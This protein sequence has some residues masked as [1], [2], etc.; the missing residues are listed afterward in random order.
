MLKEIEFILGLKWVLETQILDPV[1]TQMIL[2]IKGGTI[3][4]RQ[5]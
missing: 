4:I 3:L 2:M 5:I 1:P